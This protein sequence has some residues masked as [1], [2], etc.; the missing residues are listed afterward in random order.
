[1][2]VAATSPNGGALVDFGDVTI[3]TTVADTFNFTNWR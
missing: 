3:E 2:L 1:M